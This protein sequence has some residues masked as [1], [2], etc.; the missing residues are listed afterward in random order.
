MLINEEIYG[1]LATVY[2][3]SSSRP[4]DMVK[5]LEK[6]EWKSG[7]GAGNL[8]GPGLYTVFS[9]S[10]NNS[11]YGNFLYKI[12]V[13]GIKNFFIFLPEVY[14][15]VFG[16]G[17]DYD[18]IIAE[19]NKR[20]G[21]KAKDYKDFL[22]SQAFLHSKCAGIIFHGNHDGDVCIVF[23][24]RNVILNKYSTDN[25]KTWKPIEMSKE[26]KSNALN[27][28]GEIVDYT[29]LFK[30]KVKSL[31]VGKPIVLD[32]RYTLIPV[33]R[34][35]K[36]EY[37]KILEPDFNCEGF[38]SS[39]VAPVP[40]YNV[41]K[42][43]K[44]YGILFL[45]PEFF[46]P[47]FSDNFKKITFLKLDGRNFGRN[48]IRAAGFY[49]LESFSKFLKDHKK[50]ME[51]YK[52]ADSKNFN[53]ESEKTRKEKYLLGNS[54]FKASKEML[55]N[56]TLPE[57]LKKYLSLASFESDMNL[58]SSLGTI[59]GIMRF[60]FGFYK[61]DGK[62]ITKAKER[63]EEMKKL[64][65]KIGVDINSPK[66]KTIEKAMAISV[67]G[68]ELSIPDGKVTS[69]LPQQFCS[70]FE[71][72]FASS[73]FIKEM[74]KIVKNEV[75]EKFYYHKGNKVEFQ[76]R[77]YNETAE[78][79]ESRIESLKRKQKDDRLTIKARAAKEKKERER[80][81]KYIGKHQYH[82]ID[83]QNYFDY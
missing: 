44:L 83:E 66:M 25:G 64:C 41:Y 63:Q 48:S 10:S 60:K 29:K 6:G 58:L 4:E 50:E 76:H 1:N 43:N 82:I 7:A 17:F 46:A 2:H 16:T 39:I 3:R 72:I 80:N 24:P 77:K 70:Y 36:N 78:S 33:K 49:N 34:I 65:E 67:I 73:G 38:Y 71:K 52:N 56:I 26:H 23:E 30:Q 35:K 18:Q 15:K 37:K 9:L 51:D 55:K 61:D 12:H 42:N 62:K 59:D 68:V 31:E 13:K 47:D 45:A 74:P 69:V 53:R 81:H 21:I 11:T 57:E 54:K 75:Y 22:H 19:Q 28:G 79:F 40:T 8:Y 20:F 5:W 27:K 32:S 14:N